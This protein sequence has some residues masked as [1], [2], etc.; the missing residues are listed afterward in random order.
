MSNYNV[1]FRVGVD[2]EKQVEAR[3]ENE[4]REIALGQFVSRSLEDYLREVDFYATTEP[5]IVD[6]WELEDED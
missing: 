3:D 6:S 5:E 2:I 4:A 1:V